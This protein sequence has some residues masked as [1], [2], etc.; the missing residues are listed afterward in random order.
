MSY[1]PKLDKEFGGFKSWMDLRKEQGL[2]VSDVEQ[3]VVEHLRTLRQGL[4]AINPPFG[5]KYV[6][7]I[8]YKDILAARPKGPRSLP[9][10]A[11]RRSALRQDARRMARPWRGMRAGHSGRGLAAQ[12]DTGMGGNTWTDVI[13]FPTTGRKSRDGPSTTPSRSSTSSKGGSTTSARTM[14]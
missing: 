11:L 13:H 5:T 6:E 14:T 10:Q 12:E 4:E 1:F 9:Y 7:P 3:E 2:D 8:P